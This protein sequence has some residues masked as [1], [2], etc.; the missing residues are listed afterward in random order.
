ML[1]V[2]AGCALREGGILAMGFFIDRRCGSRGDQDGVER[3]RQC[4]RSKDGQRADYPQTVC[5]VGG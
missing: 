2:G 1:V 4:G 3:R 5:C